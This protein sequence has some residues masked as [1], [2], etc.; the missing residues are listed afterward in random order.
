MNWARSLE[1]LSI[2]TYADGYLVWN[3]IDRF[4]IDSYRQM[5]TP[6]DACAAWEKTDFSTFDHAQA[7][8][9]IG[10]ILVGLVREHDLTYGEISS[11]LLDVRTSDAKY[12]IRVER[13]PEDPDKSGSMA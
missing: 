6:D 9:E 2:T 11:I 10:S 3:Q 7:V 1:H 13:H 8:Q 5:L 12:H 4:W